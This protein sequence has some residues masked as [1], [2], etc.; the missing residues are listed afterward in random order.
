MPQKPFDIFLSYKSEEIEWVKQLKEDLRRRG[1]KV[2]LDQ[3]EIRWGDHFAEALEKALELSKTMG[4]VVT[5]ESINSN[6]VKEEYYR[7]LS[8]VNE[9]QLR[10]IPILLRTAVIPGF[11]K[12]RQYADFTNKDQYERNVDRL[13]WP[14]IT[15]QRIVIAWLPYP[16]RQKVFH[17]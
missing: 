15:G 9:D 1:V 7:A 2:W 10:L 6:W 8:L 3:D 17:I 14:G 5:P 12:G 13:V 4:L 11:L 16:Q